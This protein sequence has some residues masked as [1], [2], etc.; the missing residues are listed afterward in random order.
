MEGFSFQAIIQ[1]LFSKPN[2]AIPLAQHLAKC[3][4]YELKGIDAL[5]PE[6][7]EKELKLL[8]IMKEKGMPMYMVDGFRSAKRQDELF[9]QVPAVTKARALQSL[10]Q[11]TIAVDNAFVG[12]NYNPPNEHWW[13]VYGEVA[14]SLGLEWGGGWKFVDRPHVQLKYLGSTPTEEVRSYFCLK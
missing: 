4:L 14:E 6:L 11:Y 12:Y 2:F 5:Y 1:R 3:H 10:H 7:K 13:D 9:T 8:A